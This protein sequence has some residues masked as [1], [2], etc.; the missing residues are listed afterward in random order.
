MGTP[1]PALAQRASLSEV[2]K[3]VRGEE[4]PATAGGVE[5][6]ATAEDGRP[7]I[8]LGMMHVTAYRDWRPAR[9]YTLWPRITVPLDGDVGAFSRL[10]P[11]IRDAV[12]AALA[13]VV[14]LDWPDESKIDVAIAGQ[15]AKSRVERVVG[16]GGL[17]ALDFINMQVQVF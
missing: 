13:E 3:V 5:L 12:S 6:P 16:D 10:E 17:D 7:Y 14:Q 1:A 9:T 4:D 15:V 11:R 2:T 8:Y